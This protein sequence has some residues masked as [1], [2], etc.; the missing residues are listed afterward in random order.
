MRRKE[1][2]KEEMERRETETER[3]KEHAEGTEDER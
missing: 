2:M 1:G 3:R